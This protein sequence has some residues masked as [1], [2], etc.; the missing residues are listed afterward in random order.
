MLCSNCHRLVHAGHKQI[1]RDAARFDESFVKYKKPIDYGKCRNCGRALNKRNK[2]CSQE[3]AKI[4]QRKVQRPSEK[5]LRKL[6][7]EHS[8]CAVVRMFGV[9]DNT[10]RKWEKYYHNNNYEIILG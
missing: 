5:E 7:K 10:I 6:L 4:V 3:C 1:P 8:Y 9:S 2:Y